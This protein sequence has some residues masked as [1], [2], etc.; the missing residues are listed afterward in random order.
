MAMFGLGRFLEE[1]QDMAIAL[2]VVGIVIAFGASFMGDQSEDILADNGGDTNSTAYQ[3]AT[4]AESGLL[5][6]SQG[7]GDVVA[8]AVIVVVLA[9]LFILSRMNN[10]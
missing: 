9:I 8:V 4:E 5:D 10:R 2:V 3:A 6:L 7:I 1:F